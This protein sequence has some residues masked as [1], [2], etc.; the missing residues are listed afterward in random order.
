MVIGDRATNIPGLCENYFFFVFMF[1]LWHFA[2][3]TKMNGLVSRMVCLSSIFLLLLSAAFARKSQD[4][5][6]GGKENKLRTFL[7][8]LNY[9]FK[10]G[11]EP[12]KNVNY[13]Q[14]Q[15]K[16]SWH[17]MWHPRCCSLYVVYLPTSIPSPFSSV[18]PGNK[19]RWR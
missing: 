2:S 19:S 6:C 12:T 13:I 10:M 3:P 18:N 5:H 4:L 17:L 1:R 16:I 14:H 9:F 7:G 15:L 8:T 11:S